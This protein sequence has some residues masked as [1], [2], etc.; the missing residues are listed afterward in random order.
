MTR[1]ATWRTAAAARRAP[2]AG[3]VGEA[4][5]HGGETAERP[6]AVRAFLAVEVSPSIHAALVTLKHE[7]E[8]SGAAVRWARD[9]GLHATVKFLGAVPEARLPALRAALT[10]AVGKTGAMIAGVRGLGVFPT[11]TRPRVVWVGLDCPPLARVAAAVDTAL[12]PLGFAP[13]TRPFRAHITL[14]RVNGPHGRQRLEAA[15]RAHWSDDFGRCA[16]G[17]LV[18]FRSDLRRDGAVYTKLWTI[19]FGG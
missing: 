14:G 3:A 17:G 1:T 2:H 18:G 11:L 19:P 10:D 15:L 8:R 7:L 6:P 16:I 13:E 5:D 4:V 9:D 12:T